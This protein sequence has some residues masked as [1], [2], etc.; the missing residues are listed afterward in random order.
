MSDEGVGGRVPAEG[1]DA[2]LQDG[3]FLGGVLDLEVAHVGAVELQGLAPRRAGNAAHLQVDG[4]EV[5]R[6]HVQ[7]Q[8]AQRRLEVR[9][10]HVLQRKGGAGGFMRRG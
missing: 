8:F 1:A 4:H 7:P 9:P 10:R 5:R 3:K 6:P 2:E